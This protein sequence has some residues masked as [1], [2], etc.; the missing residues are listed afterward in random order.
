MLKKVEEDEK[1]EEIFL[2][3]YGDIFVL[4]V[5]LVAVMEEEIDMGF[6]FDRQMKNKEGEEE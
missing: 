4:I 5:L 3:V 6:K 2:G 1:K